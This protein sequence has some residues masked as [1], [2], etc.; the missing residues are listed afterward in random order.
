MQRIKYSFRKQCIGLGLLFFALMVVLAFIYDLHHIHDRKAPSQKQRI[1]D[2]LAGILLNERQR[3]YEDPAG[4]FRMAV[5][6]DW[7]EDHPAPDDRPYDVVFTSV[8]GC[9]ISVIVSP[10]GDKTFSSLLHDIHGIQDRFGINMNIEKT[11]FRSL[12][13]VRRV[14]TLHYSRVIVID[15][16]KD[17]LA[18]EIQLGIP[19]RYVDQSEQILESILERYQPGPFIHDD[20]A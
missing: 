7:K 14:T 19:H 16:I 8:Y 6:S 9:D 5:P 17:G 13:A 12:P 15:F 20:A 4:R 10:V 3:T 1:G 2:D 18:H 11:T